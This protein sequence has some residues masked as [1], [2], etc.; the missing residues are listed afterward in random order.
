MTNKAIFIIYFILL[1]R[2]GWAIPHPTGAE[3][4]NGKGY[5]SDIQA[6]RYTRVL[7]VTPI[8]NP[9]KTVDYN[10]LIFQPKVKKELRDKYE[11]QFGS[12]VAERTLHSDIQATANDNSYSAI[13]VEQEQLNEQQEFGEFVFKRLSEHH[14][15][16]FT[17]TNPKLR[18]LY[19]MKERISNVKLEVKKGYQVKI[20]YS[21]S[22]NYLDFKVSNPYEIDAKLTLQM[23][24]TEFGPSDV[25]EQVI[26]IGYNLDKKTKLDSKFGISENEFSVTG[27][28]RI[29]KILSASITSSLTA[30]ED[31]PGDHER[32]LLFGLTWTH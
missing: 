12:S 2:P 27:K 31:T 14:V 5:I 13:Y 21:F 24:P 1:A 18:P 32:L 28:R 4:G 26:A 23:D 3:F 20:H 7:E 9:D 16:E 22:G 29:S 6:E 15:D 19:E 17:K 10:H 30:L 11:E 8:L 25:T